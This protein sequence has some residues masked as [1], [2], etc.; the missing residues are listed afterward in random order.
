M[1]FPDAFLSFGVFPLFTDNFNLENIS[2]NMQLFSAPVSNKAFISLSC[3]LMGMVVPVFLPNIMLKTCSKS[4]EM[5]ST[6]YTSGLYLHSSHVSMASPSEVSM[7]SS[8]SLTSYSGNCMSCIRLTS[9]LDIS[10]L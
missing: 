7:S 1:T 6:K 5:H 10:C 4:Q 2:A 3:M 8:G 9:F